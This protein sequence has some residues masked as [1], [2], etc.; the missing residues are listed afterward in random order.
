MRLAYNEL[1]HLNG[2]DEA[3]EAL[4]GPDARTQLTWLDLSFN[5]LSTVPDQLLHYPNLSVLYLHGNAISQ[6]SE[7]RKLAALT[8]LQKLTLHGCPIYQSRLN[9]GLRNPRSGI[10]WHLRTCVLK[11]LDF[12]A[13]TNADRR[14]SMRWAEQNKPKKKRRPAEGDEGGE[15]GRG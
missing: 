2:F 15:G 1:T 6:L 14:N 8:Q 10:I 11:S 7:V 13:I 12:I 5:K 4:L 3:M 9:H